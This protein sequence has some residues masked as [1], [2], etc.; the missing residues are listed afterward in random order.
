M[1]NMWNSDWIDEKTR[2]VFLEF[3][4]Y[5]PNANLFSVVEIMFEFPNTGA[6]TPFHQ[7]FSSKLYHYSTNIAIYVAVSEC[8]FVAFNIGFVIIEYKKY[9]VLGTQKYF[10]DFFSYIE[11]IQIVFSFSIIGLFFQRLVSVGNVMNIFKESDGNT[12]ISFYTA[13]SWD[14]ILG[15]VM[16]FLIALVMLKAIK[17]LKYN[18]RTYMV[19]DVLDHAK[20]MILN[21]LIMCFVL[22]VGLGHFATLAFGK[23]M[24]DYN[25]MYSSFNSIVKFSLG[26]ADLHGLQEANRILGPIYFF[27]FIFIVIFIFMDMFVAILN[28][29][30]N[31]SRLRFDQRQSKFKLLEYVFRRLKNVA[32][33]R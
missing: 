12:F 11:L 33:I 7:I 14:Y 3:T 27:V 26:F 5:N 18:K 32:N 22:V 25:N 20:G 15:H 13:I 16:A 19:A 10:D 30:I 31:D 24:K 2:V 4:L 23:L 1:Q 28:Y 9:K 29:G 21:Y 6:V 17:L 8:L